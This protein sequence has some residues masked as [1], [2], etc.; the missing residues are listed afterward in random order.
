VFNLV[1]HDLLIVRN[2]FVAAFSSMRDWLILAFGLVV[3]AVAAR[4]GLNDLVAAGSTVPVWGPAAWFL[5]AGFSAQLFSAHRLSHF[6][7]ESP[8]APFALRAGPRRAY[9]GVALAAVLTASAIPLAVI[10]RLS[11][12]RVF[13]SALAFGWLPLLAGATAGAAWR[14]ATSRL[15]RGWQH[16]SLR[17]SRSASPPR[18]LPGGR[19]SR[20]VAMSLRRQ[21]I[22]A[23][24][25]AEAI[26]IVAGAGIAVALAAF[27]VRQAG[28][29]AAALSLTAILSIAVMLNLSRLSARL[30]RYLAFAGFSPLIPG[31]APLAGMALFLGSLTAASALLTPSRAVEAVAVAAGALTLFGLFAYMRALHYRIR[32][33]RA[34]D[35]A[36][37]IEAISAAML[38][39]AFAPLAVLFIGG[40]L[41][42]LHRRARAA[43]WILP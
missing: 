41:L 12:E 35:L 30:A 5:A 19:G 26:T 6:A 17:R 23:R 39:F 3:A 27:V 24:S 14:A 2:S 20:L 11:E 4:Q 40:R 10:F 43:T 15:Q 32:S 18:P 1:R 9:L 7:E 31:L 42:W 21:S 25:T 37:Q 28:F 33:E 38:G 8:L 29:D 36:I 16:R 13:G 34:A 22:V